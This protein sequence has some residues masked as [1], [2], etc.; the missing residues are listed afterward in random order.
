M[1]KTP[2]PYLAAAIESLVKIRGSRPS[3]VEEFVSD[4]LLWDGTLMRVQVAG[5]YLSKV[6]TRFPDFYERHH[7]D[8]WIK[9]IAIRN[10]ISYAYDDVNPAIM[11]DIVM[12]RLDTIEENMTALLRDIQ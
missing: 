11:W 2:A 4:S 6:R 1:S 12:N 3:S 10:I 5:E 7:D 9:L 8:S